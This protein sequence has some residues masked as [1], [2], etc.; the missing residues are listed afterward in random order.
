VS[1]APPD[2]PAGPP[3]ESLTGPDR[4][5]DAMRRI[6]AERLARLHGAAADVRP[7]PPFEPST[8]P[9]AERGLESGWGLEPAPGR[10]PDPE[11]PEALHALLHALR[12]ATAEPPPCGPAAEVLPFQRAPERLAERPSDR[13]PV[14][15]PG[16]ARE[17]ACDP[18]PAPGRDLARL[19]GVGPGLVWALERAG[20]SRLA[21]LAAAN[22]DALADRLGPPGAL[23][24]LDAWI[25]FA[26]KN[27]ASG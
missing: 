24:D 21:D 23:V 7:A 6:R 22:P 27:A 10:G 9:G 11:D 13:M 26:R 17:S 15:V 18:A 8:G 1:A 19:P 2:L 20:I 16:T 12:A 14:L 3:A 4:R 5:L 25:G